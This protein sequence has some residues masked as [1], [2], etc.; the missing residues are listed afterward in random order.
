MLYVDMKF[1]V[2]TTRLSFPRGIAT[3]VFYMVT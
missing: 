1:D 2:T 3:L